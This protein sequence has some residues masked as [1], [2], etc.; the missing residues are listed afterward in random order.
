MSRVVTAYYCA[1]IQE[2]SSSVSRLKKTQRTVGLF[3]NPDQSP[4]FCQ[5]KMSLQI[6]LSYC[7][8]IHLREV[9]GA[10][11]KVKIEIISFIFYNAFWRHRM[12]FQ[13][14]KMKLSWTASY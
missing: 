3:I 8:R 11:G 1:F 6:L 2:N 13:R 4:A 14:Q 10:G 12:I 7:M 5:R 9:E